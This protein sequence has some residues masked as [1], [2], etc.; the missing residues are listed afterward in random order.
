MMNIL[1]TGFEPFGAEAV[2]P[3]EAALAALMADVPA[4]VALATTVLPVR[5]A[6]AV[7]ELR[8]AILRHAPAVV[9]A[10]GQAGGRAEIS[11]ERV[12]INVDDARIPDNDCVQRIDAPVVAGGPAAYF[13]G[14]PIKALV[15]AMRA[16]G[17][18]TQVSQTAGTFLCNHV[19]YAAC[20]IAATEKPGLRAGFIHMP[21]LPEQAAAHAGAPSMAL[22]GIV[23]ALR[24]AIETVRD[25]R[26]DVRVAE[27]AVQ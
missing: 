20:H 12:A 19:F 17:I 15:A 6:A 21:F 25:V 8:A 13:S 14:L 27:G 1:V 9:I 2:N 3:S 24:V 26:E 16:R 10:T 18:P 23:A 5:Y 7:T 4:G 11:V 22:A